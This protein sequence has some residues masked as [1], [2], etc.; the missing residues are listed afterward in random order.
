MEQ[1]FRSGDHV[2]RIDVRQDSQGHYFTQ[3]DDIKDVFPQATR[4][5]VDGKGIL[6][7]LDAQGKR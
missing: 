1:H 7:L 5:R 6:F 4:F 3:L 2:E